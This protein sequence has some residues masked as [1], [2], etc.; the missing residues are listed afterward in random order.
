MKIFGIAIIVSVIIILSVIIGSCKKNVGQVAVKDTWTVIQENI[1]NLSCA[2]NGCH[3][4]TGDVN[5]AQH[6]LVLTTDVAYDN[7]VNKVPKNTAANAAGLLRVKAGDYVN[8]LLYQKI[9]CQAASQYGALMPLGGPNLT[10]GQI[11]FIKQWIIKGA[12]KTGSVVDETILD[13]KAVCEQPFVPIQAPA[14]NEG[15]QLSINSF[16]VSPNTEREV[17][18]NRITPNTSTVYVNKIIV[19]GRPNSHHFV[20]YGF[21]NLASLPPVNTVRDLYNADGSI[22][23]S[24]FFQMQNHIYLAG[25]TDVNSTYTFPAGVALKI[26][27]ATPLDLNAHYFNKQATSFTG[28]NYINMYTVPQ[29]SVVKEAQSINFPNYNFS[30]PANTRKTITTD[31]T[32]SKAVTVLTLTSH[33]HKMGEKFQIKIFGGT[34]NGEVV[35]ENTDWEHPLVLNL[36]T[37]IQLKAGEGLTSVVTYNNT[38]SQTKTFGL[39]SEDE[40]NIIFGYYY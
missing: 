21:Q 38:T 27:A 24:T 9:D 33:F 1:L 28:E 35:Y 23:A 8:S 19:Q 29:A 17:F 37:P 18:V 15:F 39:T 22:N 5:Y 16:T 25:G 36:T 4:S 13:N 14:P 10:I 3:A 30:I 12:P 26:P 40:M 34:R 20:L 2:T 7:L 31:F 6:N 32:F 11:E